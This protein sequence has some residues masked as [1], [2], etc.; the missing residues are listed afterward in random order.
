[1]AKITRLTSDQRENLAAYLDGELDEGAAQQIEVALAESPVARHEV[2]MLSRTWD[3]LNVLPGAKASEEFS[4]KTLSS[5]RAAE[6]S[7]AAVNLDAFWRLGRRVA[8]LALWTLG[9]AAFGYV[10][11]EA[12]RR[13]APD[14]S[15]RILDDY[16]IIAN[17]ENYTAV[18]DSEFLK[19]LKDKHTFADYHAPDER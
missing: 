7:H 10:G 1:M 17:L 15:E 3:L 13:M 12:S 16:D 2:E 9:L 14:E 6:Q 18:G 11:F 8:V 19:E 5:I 4:R